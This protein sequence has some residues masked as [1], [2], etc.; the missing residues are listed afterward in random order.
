MNRPQHILKSQGDEV[1]EAVEAVGLHPQHFHWAIKTLYTGMGE[2]YSADMLV[3]RPAA[4][5]ETPEVLF[6][7]GGD[8][9][10]YS[11]GTDKLM[12]HQS[13]YHWYQKME[14]VPTW[15]ENVE[16]ESGPSLWEMLIQTKQPAVSPTRFTAAEQA[17][18]LI[19]LDEWGQRTLAL[20]VLTHEQKQLL[21]VELPRIRTAVRHMDK[22]E[23]FRFAIACVL[24]W[25]LSGSFPQTVAASLLR[26]SVSVFHGMAT[27]T[28]CRR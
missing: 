18:I 27:G 3:Y 16:R 9:V 20:E 21:S 1:F 11:P 24:A 22:A 4:G 25:L 6:A 2:P 19:Q 8:V 14:W 17:D 12:D 15:L 23:W 13:A 7:F 28:P 5:P 10:V 26:W